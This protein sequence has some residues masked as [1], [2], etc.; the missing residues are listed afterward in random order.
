L[1]GVEYEYKPV[2]LV[3]DGG[4][5]NH[6]AYK[7]LNS[8]AQVPTFVHQNGTRITQSIPIIEFIE[9]CYP[10]KFN[11]LPKDLFLRAKVR[12]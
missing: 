4:E 12:K 8:M 10:E 1:K 9:E 7:S 11:L 5:Q 3:K 2:N 6:D